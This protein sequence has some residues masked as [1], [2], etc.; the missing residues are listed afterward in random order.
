MSLGE[1]C[2]SAVT[3]TICRLMESGRYIIWKRHPELVCCSRP[4]GVAM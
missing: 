3:D 4:D 2:V 1:A